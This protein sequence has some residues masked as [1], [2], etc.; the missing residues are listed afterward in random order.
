[1]ESPRTPKG[2]LN[3]PKIPGCATTR[4]SVRRNL[5]N[6][7]RE[8]RRWAKT[9]ADTLTTRILTPEELAELRNHQK[10]DRNPIT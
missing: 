9:N 7:T 1:M 6:I 2:P 4:R 5:Y 3:V 10:V 8:S